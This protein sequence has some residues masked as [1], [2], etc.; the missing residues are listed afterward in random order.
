MT[1]AP[2]KSH[3]KGISIIEMSEMFATERLAQRWFE[4]WL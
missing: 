4:K 3:R 2:G 1:K